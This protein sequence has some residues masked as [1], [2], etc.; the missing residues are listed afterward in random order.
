MEMLA[1]EVLRDLG[2][3]LFLLIGI[4]QG[5]GEQKRSGGAR[6]EEEQ[7][8]IVTVGGIALFAPVAIEFS[9]SNLPNQVRAFVYVEKD[10][11]GMG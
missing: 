9:R 3:A 8:K 11:R 2:G 1:R 6:K 4:V 5:R 7:R 10:P